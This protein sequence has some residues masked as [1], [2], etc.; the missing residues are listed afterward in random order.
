MKIFKILIAIIVLFFSFNLL[1]ST[2]APSFDAFLYS[3]RN[4]KALINYSEIKTEEECLE[5]KGVW[6][7]PGPYPK[8]ICREVMKDAMKTC[9]AGFQCQAGSCLARVKDLRK[10]NIFALGQCPKYRM[11]F[12]CLQQVHFGLASKTICHD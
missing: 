8:E 10:D 1:R 4:E 9:L 3:L 7:K 5:K 2:L 6:E 12:G 11:F